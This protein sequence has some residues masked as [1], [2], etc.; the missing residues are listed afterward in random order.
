[1]VV[2]ATKS[3]GRQWPRERGS[4]GRRGSSRWVARGA[5]SSTWAGNGLVSE[6]HA[7]P[8]NALRGTVMKPILVNAR[9]AGAAADRSPLRYCGRPPPPSGLGD[10]SEAPW[11]TPRHWQSHCT[12]ASH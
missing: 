1:M 8:R 11:Q 9:G 12:G 5:G 7:A 6:D 10:I 4:R 3:L 2:G